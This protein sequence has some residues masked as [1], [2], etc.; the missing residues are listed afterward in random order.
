VEALLALWKKLVL[1]LLVLVALLVGAAVQAVVGWRAV[2][3]GPSARALTGRS[4]EATPERIERGAQ[5]PAEVGAAVPARPDH[6]RHPPATGQHGLAARPVD[7]AEAR[8]V[9]AADLGLPSLP[10]ADEAR[11]ARR[12]ARHGGRRRRSCRRCAR[13]SSGR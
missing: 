12:V 6:A 9:R 2:L 11:S 4:F 7:A 10:H 1:S 5:R 8:R 13:G 3:F